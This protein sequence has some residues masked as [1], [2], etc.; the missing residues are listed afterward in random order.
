[1]AQTN[2]YHQ[3]ASD[4][5]KTGF[6]DRETLLP[7]HKKKLLVVQK[8]SPERIKFVV[9]QGYVVDEK[10]RFMEKVDKEVSLV[11]TA[12]DI[13]KTPEKR[14]WLERECMKLRFEGKIS[15]F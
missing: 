1:M 5:V 8:M 6:C 14:S 15:F 7:F 10:Y 4:A 12:E 9:V 11:D 3:S 2:Y 13:E